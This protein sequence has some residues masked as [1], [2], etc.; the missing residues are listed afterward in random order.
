MQKNDLTHF[1]TGGTHAQNPLGGIPM[2]QGQSVEQNET[3]QN[4][5]IYSD[6]ITL[7]KDVIGQLGLPKTLV[8]KT[9]AEATKIID[10]KFKDRVDKISMSTKDGL[11]AKIAQAQEAMK[12]VEPQ[13]QEQMFLGGM[14][15]MIGA[16]AG[17]LG[18]MSSEQSSVNEDNSL[19]PIYSDTPNKKWEDNSKKI[20]GIKDSVASYIGPIGQAFRGIEKAGNALG[21][22][23][24][25][26]TGNFVS[27]AFSPDEAIMRNNQDPDSNFGDKALGMLLPFHA[28]KISKRNE[29]NRRRE[30][31]RNQSIIA[32]SK[33]VTDFAYGGELNEGDP[34]KKLFSLS[35]TDEYNNLLATN[36]LSNQYSLNK[37][38]SPTS[39]IP[40]I[41]T[42]TDTTT[43][44][45]FDWKN[46]GK[47][48]GKIGDTLGKAA[49]YAPIAMNAYQ[50]SQLDKP[51]YERLNRLDSRFR[52][53]YVDEKSLQNISGNE[54]DN[55]VNAI[56]QMGGSEGATRNA[57]LAAGLNKSKALGQAYMSAAEQNRATNVQ[58]QQFNLGIDQANLQQS[59]AELDIN[60]RNSAAYRNEKSKYLA[61]I[62][63]GIGDIGKE[64]I[65]KQI[66]AT[67]TGYNWLGEFIKA[68][69]NATPE[70]VAEA[71]SKENPSSQKKLGGLLMKKYK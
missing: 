62:G 53:E 44:N 51:T 5:F 26:D 28:S 17:A 11:L 19:N 36:N 58:G 57:I 52:P 60:D 6:R 14:M 27:S 70:Q 9:V 68:N 13:Q 3:K 1:N 69:P 25:G 41:R 48:S 46:I 45:G 7:T 50:L 2:G 42:S 21:D 37:Y 61:E 30:F 55:T 15:G 65:Y 32:S 18:N 71:Y 31:E 54:Y 64:Q 8:G 23:I 29:D 59:N 35:D 47:Y 12:P 24:G 49:R 56:T 67:T 40:N 16:G 63:N 38:L 10:S 39:E 4:N 43:T 22:S 20:G 66:A 34:R 33:G